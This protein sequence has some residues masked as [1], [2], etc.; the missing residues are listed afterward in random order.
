MDNT[1]LNTNTPA[2]GGTSANDNTVQDMLSSQAQSDFLTNLASST[3]GLG[4]IAAAYFAGK[5]IVASADAKAKYLK[6]QEE[7]D[8]ARVALAAQEQARNTLINASKAIADIGNAVSKGSLSPQ[9][10]SDM[11]AVLMG[12]KGMGF[13]N[14]KVDFHNKQISIDGKLDPDSNKIYTFTQNADNPNQYTYTDENG[15]QKT[16]PANQVLP[17]DR[18]KAR[19]A[20]SLT[21]EEL[22]TQKART[23]DIEVDTQ[24]KLNSPLPGATKEPN[25]NTVARTW[26]SANKETLAEAQKGLYYR[27]K[28]S[29]YRAAYLSAKNQGIEDLVSGDMVAL[30]NAL[31]KVGDNSFSAQ[32]APLQ[33]S[34][35]TSSYP[36]ANPN[37]G[38][39]KVIKVR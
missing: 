26:L 24:R 28:A 25:K 37:A 2:A 4:G 13:G 14:Y 39:F 30:Q 31:A 3:S 20:L 1:L 10:A 29:I 19:A 38:Q 18:L 8:A 11:T 36:A 22:K 12:D 15:Q 7:K 17:I 34:S 16:I 35:Q 27:N 23:K 21:Q 5:S 32:G 9:T 6:Q 33:A